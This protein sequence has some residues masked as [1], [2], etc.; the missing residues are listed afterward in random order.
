MFKSYNE[1]QEYLSITQRQIFCNYCNSKIPA[2]FYFILLIKHGIEN[3]YCIKCY[4][5]N[6]PQLSLAPGTLYKLGIECVDFDNQLLF[7]FFQLITEDKF[8]QVKTIVKK[9][10]E[11][12]NARDLENFTPLHISIKARNFSLIDFFIASGAD[13]NVQS[14]DGVTPMMLAIQSNNYNLL[15]YLL[16]EATDMKLTDEKGNS[17]LH[18]AAKT[19]NV[20]I[21]K[22][23]LE[24]GAFIKARNEKGLT[25]LDIA[26]IDSQTQILQ[27]INELYPGIKE[28]KG[29]QLNDRK[30]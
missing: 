17:C 24:K 27:L 8:D 11:I 5:K 21:F 29:G 14:I 28:K 1:N 13:V 9:R 30:P 7:N 2:S 10:P 26:Y 6:Y 25:P 18:Y 23:L 20:E 22:L 4:K 3:H 15:N 16:G 12:V 19:G